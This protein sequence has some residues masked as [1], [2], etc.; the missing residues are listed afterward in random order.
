MLT[1]DAAEGLVALAPKRSL[2]TDS[3]SRRTSSLGLSGQSGGHALLNFSPTRWDATNRSSTRPR[4][5]ATHRPATVSVQS[6][7]QQGWWEQPAQ[8]LR[9]S[10]A[11]TL[12]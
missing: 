10:Y 11:A 1:I 5:N 7:C 9:Q 4:W 2:G 12:S 6:A 3:S 8:R